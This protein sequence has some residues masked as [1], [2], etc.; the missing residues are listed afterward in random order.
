MVLTTTGRRTGRPRSTPVLYLDDGGSYVVVASNYGRRRHPSWSYNLLAT[1][2][3]TI[4]IGTYRCEVDGRPPRR[5]GSAA[6]PGCSR[7]WPGWAT[8]RRMTDRPFRMFVLTPRR[9]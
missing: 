8:Y 7:I 4:Q 6:G 9:G 1:P 5:S 2:R 3:P